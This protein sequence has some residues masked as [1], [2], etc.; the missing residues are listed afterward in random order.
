MKVKYYLT[1]SGRSPVEELLADLSQ[2]LKTDYLDAI[3]LLEE[4]QSLS[5]PSRKR[6]RSFRRKKLMWF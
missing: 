4:G 1:M 5:M 3:I 6:L 2:E